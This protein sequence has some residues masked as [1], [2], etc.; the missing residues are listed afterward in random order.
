MRAL[1]RI[2]ANAICRQLEPPLAQSYRCASGQ[3]LRLPRE[4]RL[5]E[6]P[7]KEL[8]A[9]VDPTVPSVIQI[10]SRTTRQDGHSLILFYRRQAAGE[11]RVHKIG[12]GGYG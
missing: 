4:L 12:V 1:D 2:D 10:S 8:F 11:W 9:N 5:I 7:M 3:P 6:V